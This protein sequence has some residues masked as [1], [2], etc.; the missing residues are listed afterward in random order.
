ML[1]GQFIIKL[2]PGLL[3][4]IMDFDLEPGIM[5][6][7]TSRWSLHFKP[8]GIR[9]HFKTVQEFFLNIAICNTVV[10]TNPHVDTVSGV[11]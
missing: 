7:L 3:M 6:A 11:L 5:S 10:V 4:Q 2:M 9:N 8:G 1:D